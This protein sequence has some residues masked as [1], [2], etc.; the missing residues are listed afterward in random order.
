MRE[1]GRKDKRGRRRKE[2]ASSSYFPFSKTALFPI[3]PVS[4]FSLSYLSLTHTHIH[5]CAHTH[6][7]THTHV[8]AH[9]HTHTHTLRHTHT[10]THTHMHTRTPPSP[11]HLSQKL[12][13]LLCLAVLPLQHLAVYDACQ[14]KQAGLVC[15]ESSSE[16]LQR[17]SQIT[18]E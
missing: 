12:Q 3:P 9:T 8:H 13:L 2:I 7:H 6:T 5:T 14:C 11:P 17:I 10:H 15:T 4:I 1:G 16:R 18:G